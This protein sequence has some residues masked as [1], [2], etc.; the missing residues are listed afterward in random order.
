MSE[1]N[2]ET[3]QKDKDQKME[4]GTGGKRDRRQKMELRDDR[5]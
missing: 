4:N 5:G 3:E 1:I 2:I